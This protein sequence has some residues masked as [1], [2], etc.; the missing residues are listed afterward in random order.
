MP[1]ESL[2]FLF[3]SL[4]VIITVRYFFFTAP[5]W[6]LKKGKEKKQLGDSFKWALSSFEKKDIFWSLL[7]GFIFS[8][9]GL[10]LILLLE[11][12][13]TRIYYTLTFWDCI[14]IPISWLLLAFIHD[15]Y[16]YWTHRILHQ[17]FLFKKIHRIHHQARPVSPWTSFSFHPVESFINALIIP[18]IVLVLPLHISVILFHLTLM[19]LTAVTNH[20]GYEIFPKKFKKSGLLNHW[21]SGSHHGIHHTHYQYHFGLFF[22]WWDRWCKTEKAEFRAS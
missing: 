3:I 20:I 11:N 18:L 6:C 7:S 10:I 12:D 19:T 17:P 14:Y 16:F 13:L 15:T 8:G 9:S 2:F 22:T 4:Y 21:I 1:L 5:F